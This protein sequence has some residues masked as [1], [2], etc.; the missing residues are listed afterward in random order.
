MKTL[1]DHLT[2][3]ARASIPEKDREW[4]NGRELDEKADQMVEDFFTWAWALWKEGRI[5]P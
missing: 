2:A 4:M 3:L 1:E 5:N